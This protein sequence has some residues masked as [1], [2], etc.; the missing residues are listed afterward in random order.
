MTKKGREK[1]IIAEIND[2]ILAYK[3]KYPNIIFVVY[4][5]GFIRDVDKFKEDIE[6]AEGVVVN[7]VKH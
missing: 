5:S 6:E 7:V 3:T 1:E 4:D 2:D